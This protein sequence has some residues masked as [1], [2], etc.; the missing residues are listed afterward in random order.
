MGIENTA[1][2]NTPAAP[3]HVPIDTTDIEDFGSRI[4]AVQQNADAER[5]AAYQDEAERDVT[6]ATPVPD[7]LEEAATEDASAEKPKT[8]AV[9]ASPA[10]TTPAV[11][12]AEETARKASLA[13]AARLERESVRKS[14]ELAAKAAE[15][16][17]QESKF[18][19]REKK[20]A[21][22]EKA[23]NDPDA[24]LGL[25]ADKITPEKMSQFFLEQGQPDKIAERRAR[26]AQE[27]V[28]SELT[29]LREEMAELKKEAQDKET[30]AAVVAQRQESEKRF[31]E[32]VLDLK[33]DAPLAAR[34]LEKRPKDFFAMADQTATQL[35]AAAQAEGRTA[36]WDDVI[37]DVHK[38]LHDFNSALQ[39][40]AAQTAVSSP[41]TSKKTAAAKAPT[42]SNRAA[43]D[44]STIL[45]EDET[46]ENLP[47]EE[48]VK[49]AEKRARAT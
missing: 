13:N 17:A 26:A 43:S 32:R 15:L 7:E 35:M 21:D 25:L 37:K 1:L 10:Q 44:R 29:K 36:T 14:T 5:K 45:N 22:F 28:T 2:S 41:E 23:F 6:E 42:V 30:K 20:L 34:L 39:E 8:K 4:H 3:A 24:L 47:L 31:S 12:S 19:D 11:P 18:T 49:R 27:P 9:V 33:A 40:E 48:R 16:K 38:Q 46:W